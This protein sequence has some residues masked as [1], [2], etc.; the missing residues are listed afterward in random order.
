MDPRVS[1]SD[2]GPVALEA[3][4]NYLLER[5]RIDFLRVLGVAAGRS[6]F[7]AWR[8]QV[9]CLGTFSPKRLLRSKLK[10]LIEF[11]HLD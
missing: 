5:A 7:E 9:D 10:C 2:P 8:K 6:G 11:L 4:P 1:E 3:N